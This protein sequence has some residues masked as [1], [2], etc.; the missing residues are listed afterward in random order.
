LRVFLDSNVLISAFLGSEL[1]AELLVFLKQKHQIALCPQVLEE[2][3][4]AL[5]K[6]IKLPAE[7]V[8]SWKGQLEKVVRMQ[9]DPKQ[10]P[11]RCRDPKDN[12]ILQ[13][14]LDADCDWL[15]SGDSDLTS[16]KRVERMPITTPRDFMEAMGV[17][18][19]FF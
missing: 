14:A 19:P 17:E 11:K 2:L 3:E 4:R 12:A 9:P 6:K 15:V 13:A 16:L 18:E 10:A 7:T 8:R 1:C 5:V